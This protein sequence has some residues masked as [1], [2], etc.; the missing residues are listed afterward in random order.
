MYRTTWSF[1]LEAKPRGRSVTWFGWDAPH[2]TAYLPLFGA[3]TEPAP[4][5]YHSR[6]GHMSK[7]S[8]KVA[9]WAFSMV[10]TYQDINYRL[11][12]ADVVKRA[13][14][15]ESEA[16]QA[17]ASW[18]EEA[19]NIKGDDSAAMTLLTRRSNAFVD[20]AVAEWW[21]FAFDMIAKYRGYV[22]SYNESAN[23]EVKQMYPEWWLR[24]PE[25][26]F[27]SW[28]PQGPFHGIVLD[29]QAVMLGA[30]P[31]RFP[32]RFS[33]WFMISAVSFGVVMAL[34]LLFGCRAGFV[35]RKVGTVT[36]THYF[37]V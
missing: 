24:S 1:V 14:K 2:G 11:I 13:H 30:F 29:A 34:G 20:S 7:F 15:I 17:V 5:S 3:A 9:F 21:T 35:P 28:N 26:G 6:D 32:T 12:N 8:T 27:T 25:V 4:E 19:D 16:V 31:M 10:N 22:I 36:D 37:A 33:M 18:N 23:G